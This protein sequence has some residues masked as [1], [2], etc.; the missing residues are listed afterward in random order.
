MAIAVPTVAA[1][2]GTPPFPPVTESTT[3]DQRWA[4]WQ[5]KGAA[6]DRAVRRK[7]AIAAPVVLVVAAVVLY[8]LLGR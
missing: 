3:F 4:A 2:P 1:R 7:M 5:A 6:H 8:A